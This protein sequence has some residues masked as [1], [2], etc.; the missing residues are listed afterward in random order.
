MQAKENLCVVWTGVSSSENPSKGGIG[1]G[2]KEG[3]LAQVECTA[4]GLDTRGIRI[5]ARVSCTKKKK[6]KPAGWG[7][8]VGEAQGC[9]C[10]Q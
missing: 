10:M 6:P 9:V 4:Q 3:K 1:V 7:R 5:Q 8:G 2:D